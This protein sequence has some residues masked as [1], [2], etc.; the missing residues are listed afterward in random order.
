MSYYVRICFFLLVHVSTSLV[1]IRVMWIK[2]IRVKGHTKNAD[3]LFFSD[4]NYFNERVS[5]YIMRGVNRSTD[6]R[7]W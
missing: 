2:E 3:W 7:I 1:L 4:K 5:E 6:R